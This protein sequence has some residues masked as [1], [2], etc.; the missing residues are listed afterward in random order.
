M[1]DESLP[2]EGLDEDVLHEMDYKI[3][4]EDSS[5]PLVGIDGIFGQ[6]R[7]TPY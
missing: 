3:D 6:Q 2:N 1:K 5:Y 7:P 4:V